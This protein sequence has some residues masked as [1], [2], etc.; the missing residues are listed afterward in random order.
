MKVSRSARFKIIFLVLYIG[1]FL[2]YVLL[3]SKPKYQ[4]LLKKHR[5]TT[6]YTYDYAP[7]TSYKNSPPS[8]YYKYYVDNTE[9]TG[10]TQL[11][12]ISATVIQAKLI[13]KYFPVAFDSSD[14]SNSEMLIS[15]TTFTKFG[16]KYPD[17][18][19]WVLKLIDK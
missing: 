11:N 10:S 7:G 9:F 5:I 1:G 8:I 19:N 2:T 4:K 12:D 3:Y 14:F 17:S 18:L 6:G 13:F 16:L 15:P